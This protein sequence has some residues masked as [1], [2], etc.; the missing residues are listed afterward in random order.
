MDQLWVGD[1]TV[2]DMLGRKLPRLEGGV[3]LISGE[4]KS[5]FC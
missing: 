2:Q 1:E 5:I 4:K 3:M